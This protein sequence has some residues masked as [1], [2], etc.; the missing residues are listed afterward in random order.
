M[1]SE[2]SIIRTDLFSAEDLEKPDPRI[3][4]EGF[5]NDY[6]SATTIRNES[7]KSVG[8]SK[9][10]KET[11]DLIK[12]AVTDYEER[13]NLLSKSGVKFTYSDPVHIVELD[14]ITVDPGIRK[15]GRF[16]RGRVS[17]SDSITRE[18]RPHVREER[19]DPESRG[20][21]LTILGQWFDNW[22]DFVCWGRTNKEALARALWFENLMEEY[23][24]LFTMSGVSAILYQ[25]RKS[26]KV[27]NIGENVIYGYP[28]EYYIRTEKITQVSEKTL[29]RMAIHIGLTTD[30]T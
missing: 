9:N 1:P 6:I 2:V 17:K 28:V 22:V 29:E 12:K 21:R 4:V 19:E 8:P 11:I 20:Y 15:P 30:T 16:S 5:Y 3:V 25:G 24:W 7:S 27:K 14:V 13:G 18:V 26:R 10:F 23:L